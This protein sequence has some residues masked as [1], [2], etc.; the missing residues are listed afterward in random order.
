MDA[1]AAIEL[2]EITVRFGAVTAVDR[3]SLRVARGELLAIV[4]GSGSGKTT[5]LKCVNRLCEPT[6]GTV[7]I[8]GRDVRA[9]VP[10]ELR[11]R[12]GYCI[13]RVGLFPHLDVEH[14]VGITPRLLGWDDARIRAR[15]EELLALVG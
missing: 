15:V 12:V 14:N 5:A 10:H 3:L 1:D 7:S 4:G 9:L 8:E 13:Q 2:D 6:A 11:R